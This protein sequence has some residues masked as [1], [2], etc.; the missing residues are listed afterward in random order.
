[1]SR[2]NVRFILSA[3]PRRPQEHLDARRS[4]IL[5]AARECFATQGFHRTTMVDVF[6][7]SGLSAGAVYRYF[8]SKEDIIAAI[9]AQAGAGLRAVADE[10]LAAPAETHPVDALQ[11]VLEF[12]EG[13]ARPG[14]TLG[15]ALQVWAEALRRP[16]LRDVV[17]DTYDGLAQQLTTACRR[18]A[19]RGDL[20]EG[21]DPESLGRL[22]FS[23]VPG[24]VLR[25]LLLEPDLSAAAFADDVRAVLGPARDGS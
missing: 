8:P 12:V 16:P 23:L 21:M 13:E 24:F 18:A 25:R 2:T 7:R 15:I 3:M 19:D 14:G 11:H 4:Q 20:P 9:A 10:V 17:G 1:M 6:E 5:E 22:L